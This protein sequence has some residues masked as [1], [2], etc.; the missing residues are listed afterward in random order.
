MNKYLDRNRRQFLKIM[1]GA[2]LSA[3]APLL[4]AKQESSN[5][6]T[7]SIPVSGERLPVIGLGTSRVFNVENDAAELSNLREVIRILSSV[8]NS[9]VDSSPMYGEAE[10]VVG[11]LV[12]N[13]DV[14]RQLFF[15]TKVWTRGRQAGI[16][17]MQQSMR[18]M[19][20]KTIDLMQIHNLVDWKTH[21]TTLRDWKERRLIRY[22]GIT[23]YNESAHDAVLQVMKHTPLDFLQ[24]NYSLAEPEAGNRILPLAQEKGIAIIANRPFARGALFHATKGKPLPAWA[25]EID[26]ATWA[27][28]FLKFV[29]SH[30]AITCTIPGTSKPKHMLDN[31]VAGKGLMPDN[32]MRKKMQAFV[33]SF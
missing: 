9:M 13:L 26:C 11:E 28:L 21:I 10:R 4:S 20:T 5:T 12:E 16:E 22:L 24:I 31:Q 2:G 18:L 17:Q 30:P 27:Q 33:T 14:H 19:R 8:E 32:G 6:I 7:K 15:A 1:G 25:G 29:I 23:H 3:M